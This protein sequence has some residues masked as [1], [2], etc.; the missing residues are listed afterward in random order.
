MARDMVR[1]CHAPEQ[2]VTLTGAKSAGGGVFLLACEDLGRM[3]DNLFIPRLRFLFSF[4][5]K[6]E[7]RSRTLIP[8]RGPGSALVMSCV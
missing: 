8:L 4:L 5:F 2:R 6:V 7:I 1:A 3:V